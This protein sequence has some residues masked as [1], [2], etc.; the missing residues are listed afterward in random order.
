[1]LS[2]ADITIKQGPKIIIDSSDIIINYGVHYGLVGPNGCGK[3]T[4]LNFIIDNIDPNIKSYVVNQDIVIEPNQTVLDFMLRADLKIYNINQQ[5]LN[6]ELQMD[7]EDVSDEIMEQYQELV[8]SVEYQMYDRYIVESKKILKGLGITEYEKQ[9]SEYSGGWRM[10]LAI[11]KSLII[12]PNLLIM[13]EPTNH[14]D[15]NAVIWL[16]NY[17]ETYNKTLIITS[18]QIDFINQ[19]SNV[20]WYIGNPDF[21]LPKLYAV[22]GNYDKLLETL[23]DIKKAG[24]TKY[25][26]MEAEISRMKK[27]STPKNVIDKFIIDSD[28]P[29]PP[30]DY[31]VKIEFP[32]VPH[33]SNQRII[34][35][36]NVYFGYTNLL[37]RNSDFSVGLSDRIVIVGSNGAGKTTLFKL[38]LG[39]IKPNQGEVIKD[40]RAR[41]GYYHQQIMEKLPLHLTPIEYLQELNSNLDIQKCRSIFGKIGLKKID[42]VDPCT[43]EIEKLSGGQKARVSL[44]S[45]MINDP[46]IILLDEPTNHLDIESIQGLIEGINSYNGGIIMIT[47]DMHVI[48]STENIRVIE[49]IDGNL[50]EIRNGIDEYIDKFDLN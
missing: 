4:L 13:D 49:L 8:E 5:V 15:L 35:F 43:I 28:I 10:R 19:F 34:R 6:F 41:I 20:I 44:S 45:I 42:S 9:V 3:T 37:I 14:L 7:Q 18:H 39:E 12:R 31:S 50:K 32:D 2:I 24:I 1:M 22:R 21:R 29:R 26:K 46:H 17:L 38:L 48:K 33:I 25:N 36:E 16:S 40:P 27:K 47:H 11:A 23:D 30:K